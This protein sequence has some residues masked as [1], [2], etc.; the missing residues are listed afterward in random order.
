MNEPQK[1]EK[2]LRFANLS[3]VEFP[4]DSDAY[5]EHAFRN[6]EYSG[7]ETAWMENPQEMQAL[8]NYYSDSSKRLA[9]LLN[10]SSPLEWRSTVME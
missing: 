9:Y 10:M 2:L 1:A 5:Q 7:R 4:W 6:E 3:T 8:S